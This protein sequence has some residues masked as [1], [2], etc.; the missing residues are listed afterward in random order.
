MPSYFG[1]QYLIELFDDSGRVI[2]TF[3]SRT[4]KDPLQIV[5]QIETT[6]GAVLSKM[7]LSIINPSKQSIGLAMEAK[8]VTL[9]AGYPNAFGV[10]FDGE[11]NFVETPRDNL[12]R[13]L[14]LYCISGLG[15][16][17]DRVIEVD[18]EEGSKYFDI[19]DHVATDYFN[20]PPVYIGFDDDF[21]NSMG[22]AESGYNALNPHKIVLNDLAY[23]F[24]FQWMVENGKLVLMKRGAN[25]GGDQHVIN[26]N[27]GLI[28]GVA[29]NFLGTDFEMILNPRIRIGDRVKIEAET[30]TLNFSDVYFV[31]LPKEK[32]T[33]GDGEFIVKA[34][35]RYGNFYGQNS[36]KSSYTCWREGETGL[37]EGGIPFAI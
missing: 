13:R 19:L 18:F 4:E 20:S 1:R 24:K 8:K 11:I 27:N 17:Q 9:Q 25:R 15:V 21:K 5:F 32:T 3:D 16:Q 6:F 28:G 12:E 29:L 31:N 30:T 22:S 35:R 2:K 36:W 26:Q 33:I 10:I 37:S 34:L 7:D 14:T 23:D